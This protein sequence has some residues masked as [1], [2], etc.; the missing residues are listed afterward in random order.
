MKK[1]KRK[2]KIWKDS[3]KENEIEKKIQTEHLGKINQRRRKKRKNVLWEK[4]RVWRKRKEKGK[5][6]R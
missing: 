6:G 1:K 5:R 3:E 4:K 2:Q